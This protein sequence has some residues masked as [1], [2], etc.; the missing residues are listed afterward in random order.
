M[1]QFSIK[2]AKSSEQKLSGGVPPDPQGRLRRLLK[3]KQ[4][5]SVPLRNTR[6]AVFFFFQKKKQKALFR[7]AEG[8]GCPNL[9]TKSLLEG[10]DP[11]S[12]N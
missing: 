2:E 1:K 11:G 12:A 10:A 7:S 3:E 5:A 4:K 9:G 6:L 8:Y